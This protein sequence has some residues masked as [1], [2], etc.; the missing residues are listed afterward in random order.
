MLRGTHVVLRAQ[1]KND[2]DLLHRWLNDLEH[3]DTSWPTYWEFPFSRERLEQILGRES[4]ERE[5][6]RHYI[7]EAPEGRPVGYILLQHIN[8]PM[9]H[10]ELGLMIGEREAL[11]K[12]YGS[13]AIRTLL[14]FAFNQLHLHRVYL[15]CGAGN[16][17]A[18]RCYEACGFK[19]EGI[20][21]EA[22]W[23]GGRWEDELTFSILAD[24]FREGERT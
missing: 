21:R 10:A 22:Y 12:G 23:R 20:A 15:R 6:R 14:E 18:I 13:D 16:E 3:Y 19:R 9:A 5:D 17:R 8:W 1:S 11:D 4:K 24:E 2:L 7:I